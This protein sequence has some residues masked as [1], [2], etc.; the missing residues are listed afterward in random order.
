MWY[1]I[2]INDEIKYR[3]EIRSKGGQ[4]GWDNS[5]QLLIYNI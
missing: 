4:R 5:P 1:F 2:S 3:F